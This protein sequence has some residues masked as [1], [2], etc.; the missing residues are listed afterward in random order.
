MMADLF[1]GA[2]H[3][4]VY[5]LVGIGLMAIGFVVVDA[6]TPGKLNDLIWTKRGTNAALLLMANQ[7]G[8]AIIVFTAIFTSYGEFGKGLLS[9]LLFG[10][11][12]IALMTLAFYVLDW[13]TPGKLGDMFAD[14][15]PHPAAKVVAASHFG[16]ALIVCACIA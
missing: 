12:G 9:T 5:G 4:L 7:L 2:W 10:L 8:I 1:T 14:I 6:L 13:L 15:K 11:L 16:A 3:S